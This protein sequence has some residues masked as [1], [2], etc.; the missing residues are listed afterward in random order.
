MKSTRETAALLGAI[1]VA[2]LA[3]GA[4]G[5]SGGGATTGAAG[6]SSNAGATSNPNAVTLTSL[7]QDLDTS[8]CGMSTR[9][10]KNDAGT[11]TVSGTPSRVVA[12]EL[13]F[14]DALATDGVN[15]VGIADDNKKTRVSGLDDG[16]TDYTSVGL[17]A[18]PN[19]E[20]I[21]SL[22]PDLIIADTTRHKDIYGQLSK[23]APTIELK[24][25]GAGYSQVLHSDLVIAQAVN[26]CQQAEQAITAHLQAMHNLADAASTA[27]GKTFLYAVV[28]ATAFYAHSGDQWE[29][30]ILESLGL[31]S[32]LGAN[33]GARYEELTLEQLYADNPDIIFLGSTSDKTVV[34]NW[35]SSPIW[36]QLT[37]VK[38]HQVYQVDETRWSVERSL[39]T[40][41]QI[42]QDAIKDLSGQG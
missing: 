21:S 28:D 12:L 3:L 36:N 16:I 10:I 14:A 40:A 22:K 37:A 34:D 17:R 41:Q 20:A 18:T 24:S 4:C 35:K 9:A 27:N 8:Q 30:N 26:R 29:P 15:P 38:N 2:T 31:K 19:L 39:Q 7:K 11:T 33:P 1:A 32:T 5:S 6:P 13:S 42:A 23:I 25:V